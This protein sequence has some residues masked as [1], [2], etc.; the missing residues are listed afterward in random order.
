MVEQERGA[1]EMISMKDDA[2]R[3]RMMGQERD[4]EISMGL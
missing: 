2:E 1:C 4:A 3:D